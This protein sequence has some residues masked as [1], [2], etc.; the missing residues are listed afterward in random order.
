MDRGSLVSKP[1]DEFVVSIVV[2]P[3]TVYG[4]NLP[5]NRLEGYQDHSV[6][7]SKETKIANTLC[8]SIWNC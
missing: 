4:Q 2:G 5:E 7:L 8:L 1:V 3:Q 6:S